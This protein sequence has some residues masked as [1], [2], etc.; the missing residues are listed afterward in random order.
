MKYWGVLT[1]LENYAEF[2]IIKRVKLGDFYDIRIQSQFLGTLHMQ[3]KVVHQ[4]GFKFE[5]I[6]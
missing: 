5:P 4:A 6:V 2:I 1:I 3:E